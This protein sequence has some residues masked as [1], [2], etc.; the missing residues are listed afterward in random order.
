MRD[1][2]S[3][4]TPSRGDQLA[5]LQINQKKLVLS[6]LICSG[7]LDT[8]K[9]CINSC[10]VPS[11]LSV[12]SDWPEMQQMHLLSGKYCQCCSKWLLIYDCLATLLQALLDPVQTCLVSQNGY[13]SIL[14]GNLAITA[15]QL[16]KMAAFGHFLRQSFIKSRLNL[17]FKMAANPYSLG[18]LSQVT[19]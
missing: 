3:I 10:P 2:S 14:L 8:P 12:L 18:H 9:N 16:L 15:N 4:Y 7:P 6:W 11:S 1:L 17:P 19:P 13:R 5:F